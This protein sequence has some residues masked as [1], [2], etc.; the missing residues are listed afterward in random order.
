MKTVLITLGLIFIA[1]ELIEHLLLPLFWVV[2][3]R[4]RASVCGPAGMVGKIAYVTRWTDGQGLVRVDGELW[5]AASSIAFSAGDA[6]VIRQVE[7]LNL[8]VAPRK[9]PPAP[10]RG[11]G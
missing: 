6:V 8:I 5:R 11:S 4:R 9:C 3:G 10:V 1:W 7:G 2:R